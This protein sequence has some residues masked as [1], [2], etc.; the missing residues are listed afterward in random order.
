[1]AICF[2]KRLQND[3]KL[4]KIYEINGNNGKDET[5]YVGKYCEKL[6]RFC[7]VCF[8]LYIGY[9]GMNEKTTNKLKQTAK[10]DVFA[11]SGMMKGYKEE[12]A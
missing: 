7:V 9:S 2:E 3:L 8:N 12:R 4:G 11:S 5:E 10:E 1:M 6:D